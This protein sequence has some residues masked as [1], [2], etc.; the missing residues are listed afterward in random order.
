MKIFKT[1]N[2]CVLLI[3]SLV[4]LTFSQASAREKGQIVQSMKDRLAAVK[5]LK[6]DGIVGE[7]HNGYLA[8]VGGAEKADVVSAENQDRKELYEIIAKEQGTSI[9]VIEKNM[10][11]VKAQRAETGDFFQ[12][13]DGAWVKK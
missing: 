9:Q 10:G 7:T 11:V 6:T 2:I 8:F 12:T 3:V 13:K 1:I 5:Q 4:F